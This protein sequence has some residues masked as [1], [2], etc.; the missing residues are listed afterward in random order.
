MAEVPEMECGP[1]PK[2]SDPGRFPWPKLCPLFP[3]TEDG[4]PHLT[5]ATVDSLDVDR[6]NMRRRLGLDQLNYLV[7]EPERQGLDP[8]D[9]ESIGLVTV[10]KALSPRERSTLIRAVLAKG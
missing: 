9:W 8:I 4:Q 10:E 6:H 2:R 7:E 5:G 3:H 1:F